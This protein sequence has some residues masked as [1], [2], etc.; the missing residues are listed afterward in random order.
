MEDRETYSIDDFWADIDRYNV[1]NSRQPGDV[2]TKE[3]MEH[4]GLTKY[5]AHDMIE[6]AVASGEYEYVRWS[7]G[8]VL[9][10]IKK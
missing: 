10:K 6:K 2:T 3:L 8:K 7:K 1:Y 5:Q 4:Y 9:R